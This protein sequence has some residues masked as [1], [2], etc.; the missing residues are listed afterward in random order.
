MA[1][2]TI[3]EL[4]TRYGVALLI[5]L[6]DRGTGA[7]PTEPDADLFARAIADAGAMIDGFLKVRY[8]LPIA[9]DVPP[10]LT[11]LCQAVAIYKAHAAVT[12]PKIQKDYDDARAM[13]LQIS[14]GVLKLD[15]AGVEPAAS[16]SN[17]VRFTDRERPFTQDNL[18]GYL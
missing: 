12:T 15:I 8:T 4:Q 3:D 10:L 7:A 2:C 14:N 5:Q 6:S 9:G 16:G 11:D 17:G 13:L 1:Y 18:K